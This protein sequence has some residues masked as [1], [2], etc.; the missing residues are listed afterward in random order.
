MTIN[1]IKIR[2]YLQIKKVILNSILYIYIVYI[3][4]LIQKYV[5]GTYLV[6][7]DGVHTNQKYVPVKLYTAHHVY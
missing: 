2:V 3:K 1:N 6:C 5:P 7:V 4:T